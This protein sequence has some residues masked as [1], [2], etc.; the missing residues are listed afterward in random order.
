[1]WVEDR[2]EG[3]VKWIADMGVRVKRQ[4]D[5]LDGNVELYAVLC[6]LALALFMILVLVACNC[7]LTCCQCHKSRRRERKRFR[8]DEYDEGYCQQIL[9]LLRRQQVVE[10]E[11]E[12]RRRV[13]DE[14]FAVKNQYYAY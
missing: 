5:N 11:W 12:E 9:S 7:A 13:R 6:L 3:I 2:F 1:M 14:Y 10:R 4:T 8:K